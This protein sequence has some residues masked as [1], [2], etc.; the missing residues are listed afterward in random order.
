MVSI[1]EERENRI[2][3][4]VVNNDPKVFGQR[5][6]KY[7]TAVHGDEEGC[8]GRR[9]ERGLRSQVSGF[10]HVTFEIRVR[11]SSLYLLSRQ[12]DHESGIQEQHKFGS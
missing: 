5:K 1:S 10:G 11:H 3:E 7:G 8:W 4:Q 9:R 6:W 2:F 12:L